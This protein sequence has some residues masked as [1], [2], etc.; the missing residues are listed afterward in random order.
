MLTLKDDGRRFIYVIPEMMA[1]CLVRAALMELALHNRIDTD[2]RTLIVLDTTPIGEVFVDSVLATVSRPAFNLSV[3]H[4]M[5]QLVPLA[6]SI[7]EKALVRLCERGVLR[8]KDETF[9]WFFETRRYPLIDGR[10]VQEAKQRVLAIL[11]H[12]QIPDPRDVCLISLV[13]EAELT[14]HIVPIPNIKHANERLAQLV[15]LDLIARCIR[16]H[17]YPYAREHI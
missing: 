12:D 1:P 2:L 9:L 5:K 11:V 7:R 15:K 13:R 16:R 8:K 6:P 3:T 17:I 4:M 10:N 14:R